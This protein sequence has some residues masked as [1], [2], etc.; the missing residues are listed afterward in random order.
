M[1]AK[2]S[3]KN[4]YKKYFCNLTFGTNIFFFTEIYVACMCCLAWTTHMIFGKQIQNSKLDFFFNH[5]KKQTGIINDI[6]EHTCRTSPPG[7]LWH[8]I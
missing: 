5:L 8:V 3:I 1:F 6:S 7:Y 2:V 4:I